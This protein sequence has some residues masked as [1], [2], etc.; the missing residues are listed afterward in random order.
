MIT[1]SDIQ[2]VEF[3]KEMRGYS[4][5]EVDKFLD[6]LTVDYE[7]VLS[8]NA[9]LKKTIEDMTARL[10]EYKTQEGA[11]IKTLETAKS[12]MNDISASAEKRADILLKNAQLDAE[13]QTRQASESVKRLKEEEE[14]LTRRVAQLKN[15]FRG[16]LQA[17]LDRFDDL[18]EDIFGTGANDVVASVEQTNPAS[19]AAP[20]DVYDDSDLFKTRMNIRRD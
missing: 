7:A 16:I 1:P 3:G 18:T 13:L 15:R 4:Q 2:A 8:E 6:D 17:E 5:Q 10:E 14:K 9:S 12:L 19:E 20:A 11:V